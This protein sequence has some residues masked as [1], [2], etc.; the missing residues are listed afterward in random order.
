[1]RDVA[2]TRRNPVEIQITHLSTNTHRTPQ[3]CLAPGKGPV[4]QQ[5]R[6]RQ[7]TG[8]QLLAQSK[9]E[10]KLSSKTYQPSLEAELRLRKLG[11][12]E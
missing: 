10:L 8:V 12:S 2:R 6:T 3:K 4:P 7:V 5:N 9:G 11:L 1:M